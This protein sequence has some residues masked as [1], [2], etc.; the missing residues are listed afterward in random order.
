MID[1]GAVLTS[2]LLLLLAV[3]LSVAAVGVSKAAGTTPVDPTATSI[4]SSA[5]SVSPGGSVT[6][7]AFVSDTSASPFPPTGVVSWGDE[8]AGGTFSAPVC[9]LSPAGSV[10]SECSVEYT[11]VATS[12]ATLSIVGSYAGDLNHSSSAGLATIPVISPSAT[13]ISANS[14]SVISG[15]VI[16][17]TVTVTDENTGPKNAPLGDVSWSDGGAGGSFSATQCSL[18]QANNY[19]S[20]CTVTYTAPSGLTGALSVE[21]SATYAGDALS[22]P[23][24]GKASLIVVPATIPM[25]V[26]FVMVGNS[27]GVVAPTFTYTVSNETQ[28]VFL[29]AT[30]TTYTV[31]VNTEWF[32]SNQLGNSSKSDAWNLNG[33]AQG[34]AR[35]S[36]GATDGGSSMRF[37]YY[38]QYFVDLGYQVVGGTAG[39]SIRPFVTFTSFGVTID[40]EAPGQTWVDVGTS[41]AYPAL[42]PGS[43]GNDRWIAQNVSGTVTGPGN[44]SPIYYHQFNLSVSFA[45][46]DSPSTQAPPTFFA[47]SMGSRFNVSIASL[48]SKLWLDAGSKY[49]LTDPLAGANS[50]VRWSAGNSSSGAV[51]D[52]DI[53]VTY[54]K[55][56]QVVASFKITDGSTAAIV[57]K[58][59]STPVLAS[60]AGVSGAE[61]VTI[62]LATKP[63]QVWLDSGTAYSIPNVLLALPGERWIATGD[64]TGTVALGATVSQTYYHQFL[65]NV[66][67][68]AVGAPSSPPILT[69][70]TLG[71]QAQSPLIVQ[72]SPI[73]SGSTVWVD[74]GTQFFVAD[75]LAGDRWYAP[76]ASGGLASSNMTVTF[77]HQ[78]QIEV[79]LKVL[80]GGLPAQSS[81]LGT[82]GGQ[83]FTELLGTE[84]VGVW[85]DSG[86]NFTI[87]QTLLQLP[88]E[89]WVAASDMTRNATSPTTVTQLYYHQ[90]LLNLSSSGAPPASSPAVGFVSM[91]ERTDVILGQGSSAIWADVGTNFNVQNVINGATGERW[92]SGVLGGTVTG[93]IQETVS[94]FHQ[95]LLNY[96]YATI[97]G[98]M[99]PPPALTIVEAGRSIA[100]NVTSQFGQFWADDGAP[101]QAAATP[102]LPGERWLS[103]T[104]TH[105]TV[106]GP[107]SLHLSFYLQFLVT[108]AAS[109][110]SGGKVTPGG[111]YNAS[112][113]ITIQAVPAQGWALGNWNG[114]GLGGYSGTDSTLFVHVLSTINET[115]QFEPS[116]TVIS[117]NGGSV[118]FTTGPSVQS[119]SAGRSAQ[120][121]VTGD[122]KVTLEAHAS[123][124]YQFVTWSGIDSNS[125]DPLSLSVS[126]PTTIQAVFAPSYMDIIG[127]PAA[128]FASCLTI[129]LARHFLLASGKQALRNMRRGRS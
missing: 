96:S 76:S 82:S 127:L 112:S 31:G 39:A 95:Y 86:T 6:V 60:L 89:R 63:L 8:G 18:G 80:G 66:S 25:T 88:T 71:T 45:V 92:S 17:F 101:W 90:A 36:F 11:T 126:A 5:A 115:A 23:S 67:Y 84:P 33:A 78:Y 75:A 53:A 73:S 65:L 16:N 40:A 15:Q 116:L 119:V 121:F 54:F 109:P 56:Y 34:T 52:A 83:A 42:I 108:T 57:T 22:S 120:T 102:P 94:Y 14:L 59:V 98:D 107:G 20:Y 47:E 124:P 21:I 79:S 10:Q 44:L 68:L 87:P 103:G 55:Q 85:L 13:T 93:Q 81:I 118:R 106:I 9:T 29:T 49:T 125:S 128:V 64:V 91:G 48:T 123:F 7:T 26:N 38:H 1:R 99:K 19:S 3:G 50:T 61:N 43:I 129:Y 114:L 110:A 2:V 62:P 30:P 4:S 97:G 24:A 37:V 74:A 111:W 28:T 32:V 35:Y 58:G 41:Y 27:Q 117:S 113:D 12:G 105:G 69:Y 51:T 70:T 77:Y 122:G 104:P 72:G 100:L 46:R